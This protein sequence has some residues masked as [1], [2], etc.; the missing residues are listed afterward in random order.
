MRD[1]IKLLLTFLAVAAASVAAVLSLAWAVRAGVAHR[2]PHYEPGTKAFY[3]A[4]RD[5]AFDPTSTATLYRDAAVR[6]TGE[7]PV[8]AELA[9][10]GAIPPLAERMPAEP[11]VYAGPDGVGRYGGTW[12]RLANAAEDVFVI[13]GR[14]SGA[15]P[16]PLVAA[17]L[18]DRAA[19]RQARRALAGQAAVD[20]DVAGGNALE[21]RRAVRRRRR[22]VLVAAGGQQQAGGLGAAELDGGRRG[23]SAAW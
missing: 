20:G 22:D 9:R 16:G 18:P 17:G 19:R 11:V 8:L 1:R 7:S 2:V 14:L 4:L 15:F 12:L 10:E 13:G 6:P 3:D 21:R 5:P 23:G